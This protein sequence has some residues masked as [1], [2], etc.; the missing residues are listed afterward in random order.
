MLFDWDWTNAETNFQRA[1]E[2]S[3]RS[4]LALDAHA[5]FPLFAR[6]RLD[7]AIAVL[8]RALALD[9]LSPALRNEPRFQALLKK[10]ENGG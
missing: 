5:N 1:L 10:V 4:P 8:N 6:G 7:E 9:P 2:L 3:P